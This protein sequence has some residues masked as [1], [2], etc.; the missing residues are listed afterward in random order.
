MAPDALLD[1][2]DTERIPAADENILNST[3]STDFITPKSRVSRTFR[4]ATLQLAQQHAFAR[5]LVNSGRLSTPHSYRNSPLSTPDRDLFAGGVA[6][7]APA[8]DAPVRDPRGNAWLI[9][10]LGGRFNAL[11]FTGSNPADANLASRLQALKNLVEPVHPVVICMA[12]HAEG[13]AKHGLSVYEDC[14]G[15]AAKRY[16]AA[17]GALYLVRPDQ[18]VAARWRR[19][20]VRAVRDAVSRALATLT[21]EFA[22]W[23]R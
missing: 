1:S 20:D 15:L 21:P 22:A 5:S 4:D 8:V 17:V 6:P 14:D 9:D 12:G 11:Y 23:Q 3:R 16:D 18:H 13:W 10:Q 19:F 2:Y 7:G